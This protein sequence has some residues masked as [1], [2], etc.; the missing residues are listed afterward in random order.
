MGEPDYYDVERELLDALNVMAKALS[1][2]V[3]VVRKETGKAMQARSAGV[4]LQNRVNEL[5]RLLRTIYDKS[6]SASVAP[7]WEAVRRALGK[8]A[9]P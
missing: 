5:E 6:G 8:E 4:L 9:Q 1:T 7:E 2:A 3:G